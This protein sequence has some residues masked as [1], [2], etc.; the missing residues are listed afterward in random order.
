M[1]KQ[2]L[3]EINIDARY[4]LFLDNLDLL[5]SY[6]NSFK[7]L[8]R[9]AIPTPPAF[10][11]TMDSGDFGLTKK[12]IVK[13]W[14]CERETIFSTI[15]NEIANSY[16]EDARFYETFITQVILNWLMTEE[17]ITTDMKRFVHVLGYDRLE[18]V[19]DFFDKYGDDKCKVLKLKYYYSV[20][21]NPKRITPFESE[22]ILELYEGDFAT[23]SRGLINLKNINLATSFEIHKSVRPIVNRLELLP[24]WLKVNA[25]QKELFDRYLNEDELDKAWLTLNSEGW[26][27]TDV[28]NSLEKLCIKNKNKSFE[29]MVEIW[30]KSWRDSLYYENIL[31]Y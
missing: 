5:P 30:I 4:N 3:K 11:S 13:H 21:K 10:I 1:V 6:F 31:T 22:Q 29:N 15:H 28:A 24:E 16:V 20:K 25:K 27:L 8:T 18:E 12:G 7:P 23:S 9:T 26:K 2:F 19:Y 17:K 14:F